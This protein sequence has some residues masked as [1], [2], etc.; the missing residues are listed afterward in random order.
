MNM[1]AQALR[2]CTADSRLINEKRFC[3]GWLKT[4]YNERVFFFRL[5]V[6]DII[7]HSDGLK[8]YPHTFWFDTIRGRL[9]GV[10]SVHNIEEIAQY[11]QE[12]LIP[13]EKF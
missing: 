4:A 8:P 3:A 1:L 7:R 2:K 6:N 13:N 5:T 11:F 10:R 12:E 9:T